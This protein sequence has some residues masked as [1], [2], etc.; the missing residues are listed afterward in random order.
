MALSK[1][2][3]AALYKCPKQDLPGAVEQILK[4]HGYESFFNPSLVIAAALPV[5]ESLLGLEWRLIEAT[6]PSFILS[7]RPIPSDK[8]GYGFALGLSARFALNCSGPSDAVDDSPI[9]SRQAEDSEITNINS[10]V[11]ARAHKWI[12]GPAP[13]V[14]S[15]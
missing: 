2:E 10:E 8:L 11:R 14:H 6:R 12:C 13:W 4:A 3:L 5:A 15:L 1:A 9:G 7:D